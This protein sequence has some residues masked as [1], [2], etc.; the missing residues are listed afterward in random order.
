MLVSTKIS[1]VAHKIVSLTILVYNLVAVKW[2]LSVI[3]EY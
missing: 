2:K 1:V 3:I